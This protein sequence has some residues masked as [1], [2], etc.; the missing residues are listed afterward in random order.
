[1]NYVNGHYQ[2]TAANPYYSNLFTSPWAIAYSPD[3]TDYMT[4]FG[5]G[6]EVPSQD[7]DIHPHLGWI[8]LCTS[9][10]QTSGHG[11]TYTDTTVHSK[12]QLQAFLST[13][14][15]GS[16]AAL[17]AA[18]GS[19]YTTFGSAGGYGTGTGLMDEDGRHVAWLGDTTGYLTNASAGVTA[20]LNSFLYNLAVQ[21]FKTIHDAF[22]TYAPKMLLMS[23]NTL[24]SH[25]GLTRSQILQAAGQYCDVLNAGISTQ[26]ILDLT[27]QYA[28]DIPLVQWEGYPANPDSDLSGYTYTGSFD[29]QAARGANYA[30]RIDFLFNSHVTSSG[31]YPILGIKWWAWLD[32]WGEKTNW[33]LVTFL[34]NAYD[35]SQ[36]I[37]ATSTD[38]W[39]FARGRE[40]ANYEDFLTSVQNANQSV[41][42][43]LASG[44]LP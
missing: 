16:I 3:D 28:G 35:G 5:P 29:T 22:K 17:N 10:T 11:V 44:S 18:W 38:Q 27:E 41:L 23:P 31:I 7:G 21:Y 26:Q 33:G 19:N 43:A 14:Y 30:S 20:D 24:N 8:V 39:G 32:S 2:V 25:G 6:A 34:D 42:Q 15:G 9:P 12:Q 36:A 37:V 40:T 1:L 4:G 13:E